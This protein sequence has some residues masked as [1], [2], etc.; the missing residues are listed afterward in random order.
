MCIHAASQSVRQAGQSV[1]QTLRLFCRTHLRTVNCQGG[2]G[3]V[4]RKTK[5]KKAAAAAATKKK[6]TTLFV[7]EEAIEKKTAEAVKAVRMWW[8]AGK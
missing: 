5:G 8:R 3:R 6:N 2:G 7:G 4:G 1:S